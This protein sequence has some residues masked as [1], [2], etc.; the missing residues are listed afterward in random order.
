MLL[1]QIVRMVNLLAHD[2][3]FVLLDMH[4]DEYGPVTGGDGFPAWAT[5]TEGAANPKLPFPNGYGNVS[6]CTGSVGKLWA[7]RLGPGAGVGLQ[8]R[9]VAALVILARTFKANKSILGS[10]TL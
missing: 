1:D 8:E 5:I 4:Q 2:H 7:D 10:T 9:Y 6:G 3:I